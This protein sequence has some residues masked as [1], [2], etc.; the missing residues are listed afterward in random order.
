[1]LITYVDLEED[2]KMIKVS[3]Y[4]PSGFNTLRGEKKTK[5][6]DMFATAYGKKL[7][8]ADDSKHTLDERV[9]SKIKNLSHLYSKNKLMLKKRHKLRET[10]ESFDFKNRRGTELD[11]PC[12]SSSLERHL[13]TPKLVL[14]IEGN[15]LFLH[16]N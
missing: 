4:P 2:P 11:V 16:S 1:M 14:P 9:K 8:P 10:V 13:F 15:T 3:P 12:K 5:E 6:L 7:L